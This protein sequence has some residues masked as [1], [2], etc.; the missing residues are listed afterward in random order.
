METKR[1]SFLNTVEAR[2]KDLIYRLEFNE[3][4]QQFHFDGFDREENCYGWNTISEGKSSML[5]LFTG[6]ME[7][8]YDYSREKP[9]SLKLVQKEWSFFEK[10]YDKISKAFIQ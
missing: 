8:R 2:E 6:Y 1:K 5:T 4:Q 10:L 9:I 7:N 3:F